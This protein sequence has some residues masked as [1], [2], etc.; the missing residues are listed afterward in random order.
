M[1]TRPLRVKKCQFYHRSPLRG[2][3]TLSGGATKR[4]VLDALESFLIEETE[5]VGRYSRK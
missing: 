1:H 2:R 4:E 3:L 5:L